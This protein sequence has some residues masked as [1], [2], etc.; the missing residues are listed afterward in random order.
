M[1]GFK[2]SGLGRNLSDSSTPA[3][4]TLPMTTLRV[5]PSIYIYICIY[6]Y[7]SEVDI[8]HKSHTDLSL[9]TIHFP[10][11]SYC[12]PLVVLWFLLVYPWFSSV[13]FPQRFAAP[14]SRDIAG[15]TP[16]NW[17]P[18]IRTATSWRAP[19]PSMH[20]RSEPSDGGAEPQEKKIHSFGPSYTS[21]K[22]L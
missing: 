21:C 4:E 12:F 19:G 17:P 10:L 9:S 8:F 2:G 5:G 7:I 18:G 22:Y 20:R 11:V 14:P 16:W 13:F 15:A 6:I 1:L 3:H